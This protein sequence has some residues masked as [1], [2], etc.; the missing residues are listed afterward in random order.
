MMASVPLHSLIP[1]GEI[2]SRS[3]ADLEGIMSLANSIQHLGLILPLAVMPEGDSKHYRIIDGNRR[4][5]A[6][7]INA[8]GDDGISVPVMIQEHDDID[9]AIEQS[10]AANIE[11]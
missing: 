11:R 4:Y 7:K 9:T 2:N 1:G 6:L 10:L 3:S 8:N 5:E